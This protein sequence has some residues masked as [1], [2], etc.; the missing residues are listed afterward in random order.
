MKFYSTPLILSLIAFSCRPEI[1]PESKSSTFLS[2]SPAYANKGDTVKIL[3]EHLE[4][5]DVRLNNEPVEYFNAGSGN[6]NFIIKTEED[7]LANI[8]IIS[9]G[10]TLT[11]NQKI[12]VNHRITAIDKSTWLNSQSANIGDLLPS[13]AQLLVTDFD[14]QGV[15]TSFKTNDWNEHY[16]FQEVQKGATATGMI[17]QLGEPSPANGDYYGISIDATE[18]KNIY[19]H[20]TLNSDPSIEINNKTFNGLFRI[21]ESPLKLVDKESL[22]NIFLNFLIYSKKETNTE[23]TLIM[24]DIKDFAPEKKINLTNGNGWTWVTKSLSSLGVTELKNANEIKRIE[25]KWAVAN[26][27][28]PTEGTVFTYI[29]HIVI[30]QG[31][32]YL[33][34]PQ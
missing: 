32:P 11:S 27:K 20:G 14:G 19:W 24:T 5:S 1:A 18:V 33:G 28:I 17:D 15:R 29:D 3:G 4:I 12:A 9:K 2:F 34:V 10:Q 22:D 25:I 16:F 8:S 30:T 13:T 6:V 26:N 7:L 31:S 23:M 21:E